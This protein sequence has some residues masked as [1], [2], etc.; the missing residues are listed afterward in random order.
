M[1]EQ[2]LCSRRAT[3]SPTQRHS[4]RR[5]VLAA[6]RTRRDQTE[7]GEAGFAMT[8]AKAVRKTR[9]KAPGLSEEVLHLFEMERWRRRKRALARDEGQ[10]P[11]LLAVLIGIIYG[12]DAHPSAESDCRNVKKH[13][14]KP[15]DIGVGELTLQQQTCWLRGFGSCA[16]TL[17]DAPRSLLGSVALQ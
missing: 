4:L 9:W 3:Q 7:R 14:R 8:A 1:S 2:R 11:G 12:L 10:C 13:I 5:D 17:A 6:H 16:G 15:C